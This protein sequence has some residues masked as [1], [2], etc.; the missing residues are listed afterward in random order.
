[1]A[2]RNT[3]T[4]KREGVGEEEAQPGEQKLPHHN[5]QWGV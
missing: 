4:Y 2:H 1:M 3:Y 5:L